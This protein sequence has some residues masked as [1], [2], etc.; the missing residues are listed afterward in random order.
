[1]SSLWLFGVLNTDRTIRFARS[2]YYKYWVQ[3]TIPTQSHYLTSILYIIRNA[4]YFI[5]AH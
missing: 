2:I 4:K 5:N 1:M 3:L